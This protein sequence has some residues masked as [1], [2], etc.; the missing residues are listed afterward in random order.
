M[1][2]VPHQCACRWPQAFAASNYPARVKRNANELAIS[3]GS[4]YPVNS[5]PTSGVGSAI[6]SA[7][8]FVTGEQDFV[9]TRQIAPPKVKVTYAAVLVAP[10]DPIHSSGSMKPQ[11]CI[12]TCRY[13]VFHPRQPTDTCLVTCPR[14]WATSLI[15]PLY[16][17]C[18]QQES[19]IREILFISGFDEAHLYLAWLRGSCHA[20]LKIKIKGAN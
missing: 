4:M 7:I 16:P 19:P 2:A 6:L 9:S 3:W 17:P 15:A 12:R 1:S 13:E 14:L 20:V 11:R 8:S 18:Y 5:S 10:V